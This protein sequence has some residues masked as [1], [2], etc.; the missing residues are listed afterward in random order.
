MDFVKIVG[1][2]EK[3]TI[4]KAQGDENIGEIFV[5]S[6]EKDFENIFKEFDM[7][8]PMKIT[9]KEKISF[10]K[11]TKCWI[12]KK[13]IN[14]IKVR[15]HDHL[16]GKYRGAAH[17]ICNLKFKRADFVPVFF[18]NLAG[19]D[20]HLFVKN[21]GVTE[22]EIRC[23]PNNDEKYTSFSKVKDNFEIRFLDSFKFMASSLS[24]L[25]D[26][27]QKSGLEK[28]VYLKKEFGKKFELLTR[29]GIY[30]YD[31]MDGIERFQE[32]LPPQK[33][34]YS[35]LNDAGVSDEDYQYAQMIWKEFKIADL[36]DYHDLYL[37]T[38]VMLLA[39]VFEAFRKICFDNYQLDPA[40]YYT[41]L[42]LSWDALLKHSQIELELL[43]D[44]DNLLM[45]EKGI[46]GGVA[47][48]PNRWG[49]T[50]NK[51]MDPYDKSQPSK[52]ITYLDANNLYGWAMMQPLPVGKFKWMNN[53]ELENWKE[54]P[55]VLEVDLEYPKELFEQHNDYPLAPERIK[56]GNVEKLIPNLWDK[57]KYVLHKKN[58]ELY[59][60]LG[61]K[62]KKIH[63][64]IRFREVPWMKSY[65]ELNTDLRAKGKNDFE[66]DFFKLMNNSVFGKTVENIRNRVNVQ[67]V[68][69]LEK[70]QKL[71]AKP[72]LKHWTRFDENL[73]GVHLNKTKMTYNK[74]VYC[75]M[76]ILDIC[77][78]LMYEFHYKY[79]NN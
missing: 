5:K 51:F 31:Y 66:K 41:A 76:S 26:N 72:N 54:I 13:E 8:K 52:F 1:L 22:G 27:L 30:P 18:H 19:Y 67:L 15:D 17:K 57:N 48:I 14:G 3:T 71:I 7:N 21:L 69:T 55:C 77:K 40:W 33:D 65:I 35:Q 68:S 39:D 4:Y 10:K 64:G 49:K 47:M 53:E 79:M 59:V 37:K 11:A 45:F 46:R 32:Q 2:K 50:N 70:A 61:L 36:G 43:A 20:S 9:E 78:T 75:G 74:P 38:D 34:F 42:G 23:I 24:A 62:I 63:R 58:L 6:L 60:D 56:V 28:F 44:P 73:I 29:K 16:T 25:V 12:C